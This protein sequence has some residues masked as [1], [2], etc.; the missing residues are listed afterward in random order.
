VSEWFESEHL[1]ANLGPYMFSAESMTRAPNE[2]SQIIALAGLTNGCVLDMCCGP[3]RHSVAFALAGWTVTGVDLSEHLLQL[4]IDNARQSGAHCDFVCH[5]MRSF[6]RPSTYDLAVLLFSSFGYNADP[7]DD[8]RALQ[9]LHSSLRRGGTLVI[10][11]VTKETVASG[12]VPVTASRRDDG[13][14]VVR[15]KSVVDNWSRVTFEWITIANGVA[16]PHHFSY[17]IYAGSE[18]VDLLTSVGFLRRKDLWRLRR[19]SIRHR[20]FPRGTDGEGLDRRHSGS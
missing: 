7:A 19:E 3:G 16:E 10:D 8:R 5:D 15:R 18:L 20:L 17:R 6:C 2:V 11:T 1:W 4:A 12:F 14:M 9:N 13:S